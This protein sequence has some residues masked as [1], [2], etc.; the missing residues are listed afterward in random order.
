MT[1]QMEFDF[2]ESTNR[3]DICYRLDGTPTLEFHYCR[4][5]GCYGSNPEHGYSFE[6]ARQEVLNWLRAEY[7]REIKYWEEV[8]EEEYR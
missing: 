6:E 3:Y 1:K 7:T 5:Y 8:K 2:M 4:E